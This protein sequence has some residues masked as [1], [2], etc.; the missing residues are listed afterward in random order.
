MYGELTSQ[1]MM[2]SRR[3]CSLT[4]YNYCHIPGETMVFTTGQLFNL[5]FVPVTAGITTDTCDLQ[6][7]VVEDEVLEA[8]PYL[9]YP[10]PLWNT[11]RPFKFT[12]Y[13]H[14]RQTNLVGTP[15]NS[16]HKSFYSPFYNLLLHCTWSIT[17][18]QSI[19]H[20]SN[21]KMFDIKSLYLKYSISL[22]FKKSDVTNN[23]MRRT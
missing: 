13:T 3:S 23:F 7:T 9:N 1:N 22:I 20:F 5:E 2:L 11:T 14:F 6:Y 18:L 17:L 10:L 21:K 16:Q 12:T 19:K 8:K 15:S 4:F